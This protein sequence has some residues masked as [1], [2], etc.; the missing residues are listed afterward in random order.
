[1]TVGSI[2]FAPLAYRSVGFDSVLDNLESMLKTAHS[3]DKFPPHNI[4][5]FNDSQYVIEL[6]IAGLKRDD[7]DITLEKGVLTIESKAKLEGEPNVQYLYKG[8]GTRAFTK[9]FKLADSIVVRGAEF[10][11]GILRVGLENIIPE[12]QKPRKIEIG[13]SIS[14]QKPQLLN[15]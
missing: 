3:V 13:N 15:E 9:T 2:S 1:M 4:I 10:K 7:I 5:K 14:F 8:I 12:E 6:A 11:D